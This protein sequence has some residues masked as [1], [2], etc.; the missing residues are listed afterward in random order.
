MNECNKVML[1]PCFV[2]EKISCV[3]VLNAMVFLAFMVNYMLRVNLTIAIVD[4]IQINGTADN[5][6]ILDVSC[7]SLSF[8]V[9][10]LHNIIYF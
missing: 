1:L 8:T 3:Q 10:L 9:C 2:S 4:M 7:L 5:S 6:T